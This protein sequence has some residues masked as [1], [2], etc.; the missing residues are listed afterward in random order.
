MLKKILLAVVVLIAILAIVVSMQPSE[1]TV[2]RSATISSPPETVFGLINDFR[3]WDAWSPWAK[4]DPNMK[5][6]YSGAEAGLGAVYSWDG[7]ADAGSG[8]MTILESRPNEQV[9]IKLDFIRPFESTA[10]TQFTVRPEGNGSQ[11]EWRMSG[12]SDFLSKA[13]FLFA[14]GADKAIGPDFEK[15]LAQMKTVA[16]GR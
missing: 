8:K 11:V 15:G 12:A 3:R 1:Y 5:V 6:T 10:N 14:G 9:R 16:E 7:N 4:I 2:V 13:F